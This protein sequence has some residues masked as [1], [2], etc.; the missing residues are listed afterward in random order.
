MCD[1]LPESFWNIA[2]HAFQVA[3]IRLSV[4]I[5]VINL[6]K[7]REKNHLEIECLTYLLNISRLEIA[8]SW[9]H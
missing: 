8:F 7:E 3:F 4:S 2:E 6:V 5:L 1:F 9:Q